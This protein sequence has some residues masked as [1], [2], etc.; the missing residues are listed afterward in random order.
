M[1][2]KFIAAFTSDGDDSIEDVTRLVKAALAAI[3]YDIKWV[4]QVL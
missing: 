3:G 2:D 4:D 1:E